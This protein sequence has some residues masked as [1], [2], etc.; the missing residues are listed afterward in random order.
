MISRRYEI[1]VNVCGYIA[2]SKSCLFT[3]ML[4]FYLFAIIPFPVSDICSYFPIVR[5][6]NEM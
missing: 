2:V 4:A 3:I 1:D 5:F 6:I